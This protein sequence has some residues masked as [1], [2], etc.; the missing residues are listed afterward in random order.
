MGVFF[1]V[2][3]FDV[4][5]ACQD[6]EYDRN[7]GL[8]SIPVWLGVP[9]ALRLAAVSHLLAFLLFLSLPWIAGSALGLSWLW[10]VVTLGIGALL[11]YEHA[12][13][14]PGDLSRVNVA[15][16]NVNALISAALLVAGLMDL[17]L[18]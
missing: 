8:K 3:G 13:V 10:V 11:L 15:F 12:L 16:F 6:Y 4:I 5:Y 17:F 7:A 2:G 14:R 1:W 9:G 18:I